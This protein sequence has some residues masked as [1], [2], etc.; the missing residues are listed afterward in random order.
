MGSGSTQSQSQAPGTLSP[1]TASL[2]NLFGAPTTVTK[3]QF[4]PSANVG[5]SGGV[6]SPQ[7]FNAL[8]GLM[9]NQ[10]LSGAEQTIFGVN[11]S[12][13]TYGS[14][15]GFQDIATQGALQ[16]NQYLQSL[17]Q[18]L[19]GNVSGQAAEALARR[20]FQQQTIPTILERAPGFSSSD[21]QRNLFTAGTDLETQIAA[22]HQAGLMQMA[23]VAPTFADA[24]STG[25]L[26]NASQIAGF[27]QLGRQMVTDVSPAGDAFRV[28][29]ALQ[30][31]TGPGLTTSGQGSS[32]STGVL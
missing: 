2:L 9:Q 4:V 11:P 19:A 28:L 15:P 10:P 6:F 25:L 7:S 22:Q 23:Q 30:S 18:E 8:G 3:G 1:V 32:K 12:V 16:G 17:G 21:L 20:Q 14:A 24:L 31:L 13:G 27:G 29:T 26:N 5:T